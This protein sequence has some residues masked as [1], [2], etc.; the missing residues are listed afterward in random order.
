VVDG[1]A[2]FGAVTTSLVLRSYEPKALR[3]AEESAQ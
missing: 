1:V 3:P 2:R